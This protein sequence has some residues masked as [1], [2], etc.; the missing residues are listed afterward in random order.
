MAV[1]LAVAVRFFRV[2]AHFLAE[3]PLDFDHE[4]RQ[5]ALQFLLIAE[6]SIVPRTK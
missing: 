5:V 2:A 6:Q 1:A 4:V 3:E